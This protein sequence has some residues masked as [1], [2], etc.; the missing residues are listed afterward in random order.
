MDIPSASR[1]GKAGEVLVAATCIVGSRGELN[2]STVMVDDEGVDLVFHRRG[3]TATMAVQ[4]K[5]RTMDATALQKQRFQADVRPATF[6]SR[7]DR[8]LLFVALDVNDATLGMAWLVPSHVFQQQ[9]FQIG[10]GKWRF[11]AAMRPG[12]VD[13][14]NP[15]RLSRR[16]LPR[17]IIETLIRLESSHSH[18]I[19]LGSSRMVN[20]PGL[21]GLSV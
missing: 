13:R 14:W 5:S 12:T 1:V 19:V 15:Y 8:F 10:N 2:A 6:H 18:G 20:R 11:T 3:G 17:R 16:E 9:A 21:L 4:V 7:V